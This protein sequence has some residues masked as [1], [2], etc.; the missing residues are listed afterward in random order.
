MNLVNRI[1][2][3][4]KPS[5]STI[6]ACTHRATLLKRF[7]KSARKRRGKDDVFENGKEPKNDKEGPLSAPHVI[8]KTLYPHAS[9]PLMPY[10]SE[11][12]PKNT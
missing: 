10:T 4:S 3:S 5:G 8:N 1:T 12:A 2:R 11:S 6:I 9:T 7:M